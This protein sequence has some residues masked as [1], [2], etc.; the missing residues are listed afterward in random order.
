MKLKAVNFNL[1]DTLWSKKPKE[2]L[3]KFFL[4]PNKISGMSSNEKVLRLR[5]RLWIKTSRDISCGNK[6]RCT[7]NALKVSI[8]VKV[9]RPRKS[10]STKNSR[11]TSWLLEAALV[12]DYVG[13]SN[14]A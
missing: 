13:P 1:I 9:S 11:H 2:K 7:K 3:K 10:L 5:K 8:E 14:P 4:L 12:D 6:S